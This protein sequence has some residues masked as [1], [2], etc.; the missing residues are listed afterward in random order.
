MQGSAALFLIDVHNQQT[1][2]PVTLQPSA[3]GTTRQQGVEV[4]GRV[5][6]ARWLALFV[7]ATVNNAHY[8]HLVTDGG[9]DLAGVPCLPGGAH[10]VR[11][12]IRRAAGRGGRVTLGGVHRRRGRR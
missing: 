3:G 8:V 9:V 7:H 1:V 10:D 2:D 4:D 11:R 12:G 5:G 6:L